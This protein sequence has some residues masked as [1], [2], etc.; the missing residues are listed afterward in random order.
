MA[1]LEKTTKFTS[2][3][4]IDKIVDA[5]M[6]AKQLPEECQNLS[7]RRGKQ[8]SISTIAE[9]WFGIYVASLFSNPNLEFIIEPILSFRR[10]GKKRKQTII[11]DL[12]IVENNVITHYFDLKMDLGFARNL[13]H[14][15]QKKDALVR[16][17]RSAKCNK[18]W[19]GNFS[20]SENIIYQMVI[21]SEHNSGK[22]FKDHLA[23]SKTLDTVDVYVFSDKSSAHPNSKQGRD[24]VK[25]DKEE[26]AR[27]EK[28]VLS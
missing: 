21:I 4:F 26:I 28:D 1:V 2:T 24:S 23:F 22:H 13:T 18:S 6:V 7:L 11:P 17:M 12:I 10:E 5:Y 19:I 15:L 16:D 3:D 25:E 20:F 27:F 9:N 14:Y 8:A